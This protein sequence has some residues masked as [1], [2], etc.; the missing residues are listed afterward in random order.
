MNKTKKYLYKVLYIIVALILLCTSFIPTTK[1]DIKKDLFADTLATPELTISSTQDEDGYCYASTTK[2]RIYFTLSLTSAPTSEVR[3]YFHAEDRTAISAAGDYYLVEDNSTETDIKELAKTTHSSNYVSL[4]EFNYKSVTIQYYVD[5]VKFSTKNNKTKE[6]NYNYFLFV[7][8][9]V[10]GAT[11]SGSNY[12]CRLTPD[13]TLAIEDNENDEMVVSYFTEQDQIKFSW[14]TETKQTDRTTY[15][16]GKDM[17]GEKWAAIYEKTVKEDYGEIIINFVIDYMHSNYKCY[18]DLNVNFYSKDDHVIVHEEIDCIEDNHY[19]SESSYKGDMDMKEASE[20]SSYFDKTVTIPAGKRV[21]RWYYLPESYGTTIIKD[22]HNNHNFRSG[23]GTITYKLSDRHAPEVEEYYVDTSSILYDGKIRLLMRFDEPVDGNGAEIKGSLQSRYDV[24]FRCKE[25]SGTNTL[26]FEADVNTDDLKS[27]SISCTY[28]DLTELT[29][30][31]TDIGYNWNSESRNKCLYQFDNFEK[32]NVSLD[33]RKPIITDAPYLSSGD[34]TRTR[35]TVVTV[36]KLT[37]G[38]IYYCYVPVNEVSKSTYE[39]EED[40]KKII[41]DTDTYANFVGGYKDFYIA[42]ASDDAEVAMTVSSPPNINGEYYLYI[43]ATSSLGKTDVAKYGKVVSGEVVA[44]YAFDNQAPTL[45]VTRNAASTASTKQFNFT[46]ED[47]FTNDQL[48]GNSIGLSEIGMRIYDSS[49]VEN[50]VDYTIWKDGIDRTTTK[51]ATT[52]ND[53][54]LTGTIEFNVVNEDLGEG[55]GL[56]NYLKCESDVVCKLNDEG[57]GSFY[58]YFYA[59]DK[60]GNITKIDDSLYTVEKY[61]LRSLF[62]YSWSSN[63]DNLY[64]K[65]NDVTV[66]G[67]EENV[68]NRN[69]DSGQK[70]QISVSNNEAVDTSLITAETTSIYKIYYQS[71]LVYQ[72]GVDA[73]FADYLETST[74]SD[75]YKTNINITPKLSGHYSI[76]LK[77][78][79]TLNPSG[80]AELYAADPIDFYVTDRKNNNVVYDNTTNY[81]S[82]NK[83]LVLT[84]KVF[85]LGTNYYYL[86]STDGVTITPYNGTS[87]YASFSS[88]TMATNYVK[89]MEYQDIQLLK[90]GY[91]QDGAQIVAFLNSAGGSA[92]Y[93]KADGQDAIKAE[94]GQTWVRYKRSSWTTGSGSEGWAYYFYSDRLEDTISIATLEGNNVQFTNAITAVVNTIIKQGKTVYL[95]DDSTLDSHN[96]PYLVSGQIH[97]EDET[98]TTTKIGNAFTSTLVFEGDTAIYS[99]YVEVSSKSYKL[100]TNMP[101]T[102]N[103]NKLYYYDS[104]GHKLVPINPKNNQ[105]LSQAMGSSVGSGVYKIIELDENGVSEFEVYIDNEAPIVS[106]SWVGTGDNSTDQTFSANLNS[107][108][109][110]DVYSAKNMTIKS[111]SSSI[112]IDPLAYVA[113]YTAPSYSFVSIQY[114]TTLA[115]SPI[116]LP[117][118]NYYVVV[119]DRSGNVYTFKAQV[120]SEDL[121][122]S[123]TV[124]NN[125][126]VYVV[127]NRQEDQIDRFEVRCDNVIQ[128]QAFNPSGN[129]YTQSGYYNIYIRD[130]YG[131]TNSNA[132]EFGSNYLFERELPKLTWYYMDSSGTPVQYNENSSKIMRI[133]RG[134]EAD[135]FYINTSKALK[136]TYEDDY[137]YEITGVSSNNIQ[138]SSIS[139]YVVINSTSDWELNIWYSAYPDVRAKYVI[140]MDTTSP[141]VQVNYR[142]SSYDLEETDAMEVAALT[143]DLN[144]SYSF[145]SVNYVK[146]TTNTRKVSEGDTINS[147]FMT[148]DITDE[149]GLQSVYIYLNDELVKS[150]EDIE[151]KF[152]SL[153]LS[154]SGAYKIVATDSFDNTRTFSFVNGATERMVASIDEAKVLSQVA[155]Q[156][157]NSAFTVKTVDNCQMMF[158]V[159]SYILTFTLEDGKL[160]LTKYI[161]N[162]VNGDHIYEKTLAAQA[163][164]DVNKAGVIAYDE[165]EFIANSAMIEEYTKTSLVQ[166]VRFFVSYDANKN[167]IIRFDCKESERLYIEATFSYDQFEEPYHYDVI[168]SKEVSEIEF[169]T[170]DSNKFAA[171]YQK[172]TRINNSFYPIL[173]NINNI[174]KIEASYSKTKE[175]INI[176]DVYTKEKGY[177]AFDTTQN[178][179]YSFKVY[180]IFGNVIEYV[181]NRSDEFIVLAFA[182]YED[183]EE[184]SFDNSYG[185]NLI[186]ANG[187]VRFEAYTDEASNLVFT[188]KNVETE[189]VTTVNGQYLNGYYSFVF[190]EVGIYKFTLMDTFGNVA[191]KNYEIKKTT[192]DVNKN[193]AILTNFNNKA[194]LKDQGYTNQ[195]ITID[196]EKIESNDIRY[197]SIISSLEQEDKG[198]KVV[199]KTEKIIYNTLTQDAVGKASRY[200]YIIVKEYRY[201]NN[202]AT[203]TASNK[204]VVDLLDGNK[205]V[206]VDA[207]TILSN[208]EFTTKFTQIVGADG[209]NDYQVL[210][211]DSYGGTDRKEVHYKEE[212]TLTITRKTRSD[213]EASVISISD[214]KAN[215]VWSNGKVTFTSNSTKFELI[216]VTNNESQVIQTLPYEFNVTSDGTYI[217]KILYLDEY[218]NEY[219]IVVNLVRQELEVDIDESI[220]TFIVDDV[221]TTRDNIK[222]SFPNNTICTYRLNSGDE[223]EYKAGDV[224][225][226]DGTYRFTVTDYAGNITSKTYKKDTICEF[227]FTVPQTDRTLINGE[228]INS[229]YVKFNTA[230]DDTTY[231][232]KTYYNDVLVEDVYE[233]YSK[234]GKWSFIIEDLAGNKTMFEFFIIT[235]DLSVFEYTS[236]NNYK[237]TELWYNAGDG[238]LV[239]Y[240]SYVVDKDSNSEFIIDENGSYTVVMT[241]MAFNN[242]I[243]FSFTINKSLPNV[244]L[245][246]CLEGEKTLNSVTID[247]VQI[248]DIVTVYKDNKLYKTVE[249]LDKSDI[250][251]ISE[252]GRYEIVVTNQ[253]GMSTTLK[254]VRT[255][256]PNVAG[257][258][259]IIIVSLLAVIGIV[260]GT[261]LRN[262]QKIDD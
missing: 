170:I 155:T 27:Q 214:A 227:E 86:N 65:I 188:V 209:S 134:L 131:N 147:N 222:I 47:K 176:S 129:K 173:N 90:I 114:Y 132:G 242:V 179:F 189:E 135:T 225:Y 26:V 62:A 14:S 199:T 258:V 236:P 92:K 20:I 87:S 40:F 171:S 37:N 29:T 219:E 80:T 159:G 239:D 246:G 19:Y 217:H 153:S 44:G 162:D 57:Y 33:L 247:G 146:G 120:C 59:I 48:V 22:A 16:L 51:N 160:Y 8:E 254:F 149:S 93:Q 205:V 117:D 233:T 128:T 38:R 63:R 13:Y 91:D 103:K 102:V 191:I 54:N 136:F 235:H 50:V 125:S 68:Y 221:V 156:Y 208:S 73:S 193:G 98:A 53:T 218:G 224:L 28:I 151:G 106:I 190:S 228:V 121:N 31:I 100:A 6:S 56:K 32:I 12:K 226:R 2:N 34:V 260:I 185:T 36:S 101:L 248:G 43:L 107:H 89:Y 261:V 116:V 108:N 169:A 202:Q 229:G 30:G 223:I 126:Y 25:G 262:R 10:E 252:G 137:V 256:V 197:I 130:I 99:N 109:N 163:F 157:G 251:T 196:E 145:T 201:Y 240:M 164:F 241:S 18:C 94:L 216:K 85:Q 23:N 148:L 21:K 253:A 83:N 249:V 119:G 231:I 95:T 82:V 67:I 175:F 70:L 88:S 259:L 213:K 104:V 71:N 161:C 111:V 198:V 166:G 238:I 110:G 122:V 74:S 7:V 142:V 105:T 133:S 97:S 250:P 194:L 158:K 230:N 76:E 177:Q 184:S 66:T 45:N 141:N 154:K 24:L 203:L 115:E 4:T 257:S 144:T 178:G 72:D 210:F 195:K 220:K 192:L 64:S 124:I 127:T 139:R 79:R 204:Y 17:A 172:V 39:S 237:I 167:I 244:K 58:Y 84:N 187:K 181:I 182:E 212:S 186:K 35:N 60:L 46:L 81:S 123:I 138:S 118:G 255:K 11:Y 61:D 143:A 49:N 75:G 1:K 206:E 245:N 41:E 5:T 3:V 207:N 183:K 211:R 96:A 232:T 150:F 168:L 165:K 15:T 9:R 140:T 243:D 174:T 200:A 78:T 180:N 42:D 215:G 234:A 69:A 152:P 52:E 113:I 112:D 77:M 55:D